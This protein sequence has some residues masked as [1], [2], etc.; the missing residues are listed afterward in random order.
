VS[1]GCITIS[2]TCELPNKAG[3]SACSSCVSLAALSLALLRE[4]CNCTA[5]QVPEPEVFAA[6]DVGMWPRGNKL[7]ARTERPYRLLVRLTYYSFQERA[8]YAVPD[9]GGLGS[10]GWTI[11]NYIG[12]MLAT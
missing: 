2:L 9:H 7:P 11:N 12:H 8:A 10:A 3:F 5:E 6:I 1:P 4:L